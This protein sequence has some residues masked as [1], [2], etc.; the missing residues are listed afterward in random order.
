MI[1]FCEECGS[2]NDIDLEKIEEDKRSFNCHNCNEIITVSASEKHVINP[3]LDDLLL[4]KSQE[5]TSHR[6][7]KIFFWNKP[8][9]R[10][11]RKKP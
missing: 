7:W 2:K 10:G 5:K 8:A 6:I 3:V 9:G 11:T 1:C 4:S